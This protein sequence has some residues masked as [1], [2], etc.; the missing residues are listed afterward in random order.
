MD[1]RESAVREQH[2]PIRYE[3]SCEDCTLDTYGGEEYLQIGREHAAENPGHRVLVSKRSWV[4]YE[5]GAD[6]A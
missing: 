4:M 6:S 5:A 3:V 1:A 2:Y